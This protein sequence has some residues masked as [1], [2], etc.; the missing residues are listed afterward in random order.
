MQKFELCYEMR[1][2][3]PPTWLAPQLLPP[4]KPEALGDWAKPKDLVLRYKYD[5]LPNGMI[6]R[7]TVRLH[8]FVRDP[9]MA[10]VT[11]VLFERDNTA[12]LVE[13]LPNGSEIELRARGPERKA[14]LSVISA[15][16]D[17]LNDSFQGLRDKVHKRIPCDCR[18]C[19]A[20]PV[21]EFFDQ[22]ALLKRNEDNRL[23]VECPR[24]YKRVDVLE[25]LDGIKLDKLPAWV[26]ELADGAS[27][28]SFIASPREIRIFLAS[29][30]ELREDRDAFDLYLRQQNDQLRK[31][32]VYLEIVRWE[33]LL[34]AMSET[35]LQDEYNKAI[36]ECEIFVSLF[37]TKTGK[38]SEEEFKVAHAHFKAHHKPLL[39]TFFK[40]AAVDIDSLPL[41]DLKSLRGFQAKLKKLGHF[42]TT[43]DN[44][45]DLKLQFRD[46][47]DRM[48][49]Q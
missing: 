38:F 39:F 17:A 15:D 4:A 18:V 23:K 14:L 12:V 9:E 48:L 30:S 19:V 8:R 6:S 43:Y 45:E 40:K 46:Q 33:N 20:G 7:L 24:S 41:K 35:R 37:F 44:V 27:L 25:L 31:E 13:V 29:S 26:G 28:E 22:K 21:P 49:E 34:D 16:L 32:G 5:F 47:L 11:G 1:D 3:K 36:R 10:W 2:S 42:Y